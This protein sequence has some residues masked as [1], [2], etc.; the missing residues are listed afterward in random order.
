SGMGAG[1]AAA[2][3]PPPETGRT[4]FAFSVRNIRIVNG[5]LTVRGLSANTRPQ[6]YSALNVQVRDFSP[7]S[8]FPFSASVKL[9]GGG[10]ATLQGTAGPIDP[11]DTARTAFRS[12]VSV[13]HLDLLASGY[14]G[15]AT[16]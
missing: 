14:L 12:T 15:P 16:G 6:V 10:E 1:K 9:A 11:G 2:P 13:R 3:A 4:G 5:T 8:P 7:N